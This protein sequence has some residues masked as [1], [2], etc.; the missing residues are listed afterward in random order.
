MEDSV[1]MWAIGAG[2]VLYVLYRFLLGRVLDRDYERELNDILN[3]D[4]FKVK[5]GFD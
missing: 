2:V 4:E 3:N 5:G 1:V